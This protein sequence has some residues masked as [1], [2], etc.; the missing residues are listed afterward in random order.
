MEREREGG[1]Q[2]NLLRIDVF[3]EMEETNKIAD[4]DRHWN[5]MEIQAIRPLT[6][7]QAN[8]RGL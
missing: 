1:N 8:P 7:N 3:R 2:S 5:P 6:E 4:T